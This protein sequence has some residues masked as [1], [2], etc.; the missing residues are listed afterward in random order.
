MAHVRDETIY[1]YDQLGPNTTIILLA[2]PKCYA[3]KKIFL[4]FM[5]DLGTTVI[6]LREEETFDPDYK[7]SI[8]SIK[9]IGSLL[10]D[11]KFKKIITHPKYSRES[12]PQNRALYDFVNDLLIAQNRKYLHYIYKKD[13]NQE[14][15]NKNIQCIAQNKIKIGIIQLYSR[16]LNQND[17]I[18]NEIYQNHMKLTS[19]ITGIIN[20]DH[21]KDKYER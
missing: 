2:Q 10:R 13:N 5:N 11:Y 1:F 12:D 19:K 3:I 18:N 8:K 9:I 6:D 17:I 14:N 20:D 16:I 4:D 15:I 7:L 21:K